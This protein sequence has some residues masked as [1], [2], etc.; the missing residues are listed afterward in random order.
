MYTYVLLYGSPLDSH[1]VGIRGRM[2]QAASCDAN[3]LLRYPVYA[4]D[5]LRR[6]ISMQNINII[7]ST[8]L[9]VRFIPHLHEVKDFMTVNN[10]P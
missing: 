1:A 9:S 8:A 3:S 4:I 7:M 2:E 5:F 6:N 10:F